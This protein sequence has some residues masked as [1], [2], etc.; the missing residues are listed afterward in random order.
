MMRP[1]T[2]PMATLTMLVAVVLTVSLPNGAF[3]ELTFGEWATG[4]GYTP[5]GPVGWKCSAGEEGIA[6]MDGVS[7]YTN[8]QE[9]YLW[10]NQISTLDAIPFQGLTNLQ[11]LNL[12]GNRITTLDANQFQGLTNL[13][14]LDLEENQ[15]STVD[16]H[17]FQGLTNLQELR[18]FQNQISTLTAHA[19]QGLTN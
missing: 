8:L 13:Q 5:P 9:L 17:A 14:R 3:A 6:S 15:I 16:A 10:C 18:L 7:S 11:R 4:Q 2:I 1:S 12:E 19:F